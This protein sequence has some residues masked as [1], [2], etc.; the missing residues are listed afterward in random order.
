MENKDNNMQE[1]WQ[2]VLQEFESVENT[3]QPQQPQQYAQQPQQYAQQPQQYAQQPQ[4]YAQQPQQYAQQPQQYQPTAIPAYDA[5]SFAVM[6]VK[7]KSK[8]PIIILIIVLAAALIGGA[9]FL[10]FQLFGG[11]GGYESL[12][13]K[14]FGG[15]GETLSDTTAD[16]T[17]DK[18]GEQFEISLTPGT[19]DFAPTVISGKTY[20][21]IESGKVYCELALKSDDQQYLS[22]KL[23]QEDETVIMQIPEL[24]DMYITV[25]AASASSMVSLSSP[26]SSVAAGNMLLSD[27]DDYYSG[28][29]SSYTAGM[30]FAQMLTELSDDQIDS[31]FKIITDAYFE[32]FTG[33]DVKSATLTAGSTTV[34]CQSYTV[35]FT[36]GNIYDFIIKL[37]EKIGDDKTFSSLLE[38]YG[39]DKSTLNMVKSMFESAKKESSDSELK[40]ELMRMVVYYDNDQIIGRSIIV[41][42]E[43]ILKIVHIINDDMISIALV[44]EDEL[45]FSI[46]VKKSGDQYATEVALIAEGE[47]LF[48]GTG[49]FTV[50]DTSVT[51][52][53]DINFDGNTMSFDI[54]STEVGGNSQFSIGMKANNEKIFDMSVDTSSIPYEDIS[55]PAV[56]DSNS[57]DMSNS[58]YYYTEQEE[59]FFEDVANN[60]EKIV[61]KISSMG[62]TDI[63]SAYI[64]SSMASM[65]SYDYDDDYGFGWDDDDDF[66][67]DDFDFDFDL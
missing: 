41:D 5:S 12:E 46:N 28:M 10:L 66:N 21:D 23:W 31:L 35:K 56:N 61:E 22:A 29:S 62:K 54:S 7:K 18:I 40:E 15:L 45:D 9:I 14:F 25:D 67:W 57:V 47:K 36:M 42:G 64:A 20:A 26:A 58:S 55:V 19:G 16:F 65:P 11:K 60:A 4:Q 39:F 43:E 52:T 3:Q 50:T 51:G 63:I 13:R 53:A 1:N 24:S 49:N 59:K 38:E 30:Q 44:V 17:S 34:S 27:Y 6:P 32:C 48:S 8:T 33:E 2:Q 37:V